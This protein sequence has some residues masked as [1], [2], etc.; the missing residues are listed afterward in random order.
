MSS[1][2]ERLLSTGSKGIKSVVMTDS[3]HTSSKYETAK[4]RLPVLN[5]ALSGDITGGVGPGLGTVAGPSKHFKSSLSLLIVAAYLKKHEDAVC[6]F[7]DN[8]FGITDDYLSAYGV[9]PARVIHT[10]IMNVEDLKFDAVKKLEELKKGDKVIFLLDSMGNLA[11]KKE[12]EDAK[13]ENSVADMSRAK[14]LKSFY[15]MITPYLT[16]KQIPFIQIAH[17]Y[18]TQERFSKAVISGGCL[19]EGTKLQMADGTLKPIEDIKCGDEVLTLM[20]DKEV[21]HTWTPETLTEGTPDC[22]EVEFDDGYVVTCSHNHPFMVQR[23]DGTRVWVKA[24]ELTELDDV[25]RI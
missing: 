2:T 19:V 8:E 11:S 24:S 9:D 7:Y 20:G 3:E 10:P 5:I 18:N 4:T 15:R 25:V 13:E 17:T 16:M 14:Q 6:V 21:T 22:F 23:K 1:L 12:I